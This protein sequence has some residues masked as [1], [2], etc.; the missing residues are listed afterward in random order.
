MHKFAKKSVRNNLEQKQL[1]H[2]I[3]GR[4]LEFTP[5]GMS[6]RETGFSGRETSHFLATLIPGFRDGMRYV[7]TNI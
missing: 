5:D 2:K 6:S 4:S 3:K 7:C 1:R